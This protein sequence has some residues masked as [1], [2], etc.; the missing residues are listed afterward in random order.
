M[1][2]CQEIWEWA[3]VVARSWARDRSF[4]SPHLCVTTNMSTESEI[5][6]IEALEKRIDQSEKA[7][8]ALELALQ[9]LPAP[10]FTSQP[11]KHT[12][13]ACIALGLSQF[14][15]SALW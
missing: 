12:Y 14:V 8:Q 2:I 3:L 6:H 4:D 7:L 9:T 11:H 10:T 1:R 5:N 13:E 15:F